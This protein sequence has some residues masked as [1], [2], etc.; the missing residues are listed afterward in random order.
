MMRRGAAASRRG[1]VEVDVTGSPPSSPPVE[2]LELA[3]LAFLV[4]GAFEGL[5]KRV[6]GYATWL[7]PI[8]DLF[9]LA[10]VA[11]WLG[12]QAPSPRR[13]PAWKLCVAFL[14][15]ATLEIFNP[16]LPSLVFG[17]AGLRASYIYAVL[18][19]IGWR[20]YDSDEK[21]VR[22]ARWMAFI[23]IITGV[24]AI[25]EVQMGRDWVEENGLQVAVDASYLGTSGEYVLR[26]SSIGNG[27]GS[28]AMMEFIGVAFLLGLA[29]I[30]R[31]PVRRLAWFLGA[32]LGVTGILLAATRIIWIM[33][34]IAA[35]VAVLL[36]GRRKLGWALSV[37][38]FGAAAIY[39]S[40]LFSSGEII[41]RY[42][43]LETPTETYQVERGYAL[44]LVPEIL[45]IYPLGAGIGWHVPRQFD[46]LGGFYSG[47]TAEHVGIHN[48]FGILAIELGIPGLAVF[49]LFTI[50]VLVIGLRGTFREANERRWIL[51]VSCYSVFAAIAVSFPFGGALIGWPGEYYWLVAGMIIRFAARAEAP[52]ARVAVV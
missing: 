31:T 18:F 33:M 14:S 48:Y 6:T 32:M 49:L 46:F 3:L 25:G 29:A 10:V 28:A 19:F 27:P 1:G 24:G 45:G 9:F 39:L 38:V 37:V 2:T 51:F 12:H 13:S 30:E 35:G 47:P 20:V 41:A 52:P 40:V 23:V 5:L 43:T 21:V 7:Y 15:I 34:G 44:L 4:Y 11:A 50:V 22:L 17:L 8:K 16:Y 36:M 42:Q 26:P